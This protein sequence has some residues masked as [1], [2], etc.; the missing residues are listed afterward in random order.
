MIETYKIITGKE[1]VKPEKLF[2][3]AKVRGA[4]N[5]THCRKIATKHSNLGVRKNFFSQRVIGK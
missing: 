4:R 1:D 5:N 3:M 2:K